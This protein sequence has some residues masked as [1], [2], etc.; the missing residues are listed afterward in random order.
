LGSA[1]TLAVDAVVEAKDTECVFGEVAVE[2]SSELGLE[3]LDIGE[4]L[5]VGQR[6]AVEGDVDHWGAPDHGDG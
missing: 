6:R 3:L 1:L 2:V 5:G 4:H